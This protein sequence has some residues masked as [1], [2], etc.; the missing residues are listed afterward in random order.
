MQMC[1]N[2]LWDGR[3]EMWCVHA[4]FNHACMGENGNREVIT[5]FTSHEIP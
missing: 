2:V 4:A 5:K 1:K 3:R